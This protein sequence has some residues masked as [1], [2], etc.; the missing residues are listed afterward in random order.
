MNGNEESG[1]PPRSSRRT[2]GGSEQSRRNS[3][4]NGLRS[5]VVFPEDMAERIAERKSKLRAEHKP[6]GVLE[7]TLIDEIARTGVQV[8]R[9]QELMLDDVARVQRNIELS[10][11]GD[12]RQQSRNTTARLARDPVRVANQLEQTKQGAELCL[13]WWRGLGESVVAHGRLTEE[14]RQ[15]AFN[16]LGTPPQ[17]RDTT[18]RV[19]AGD[20]TEGLAA[21]VAR[22]VK[23]LEDRLAHTLA[24][25]DALAREAG[26]QG[27]PVMLDKVTRQL[28]SDEARAVKRMQ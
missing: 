8:D 24:S 25:H 16:L 5:C 14:Q 10:W 2:P 26:R 6:A 3:L 23:R 17:L 18:A 7:E 12:R 1:A 22:D 15:V 20:D 19:P 9:A 27:L 11:D 28:R 4:K 13:D 21:L